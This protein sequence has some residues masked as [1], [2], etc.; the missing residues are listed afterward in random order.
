[1]LT[2]ARDLIV[3]I[4]TATHKNAPYGDRASYATEGEAF[5]AAQ[6][7][8]DVYPGG[9]VVIERTEA[10]AHFPNTEAMRLKA[11]AARGV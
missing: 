11:E 9:G 3:S 5:K 2:E 10:V 1:M 8:F 4:R 6:R 7:W